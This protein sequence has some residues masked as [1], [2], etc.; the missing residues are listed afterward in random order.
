MEARNHLG[1]YIST[2]AATVVSLASQGS[3]ATLRQCFTVTAEETEQHG[4]QEL[5]WLIAEACA[6]RKI[7]FSDVAVALDCAAF[8]QHN[9]HSEF[10]DPK[11]IAATIRFDAEEAL[12]MD[13]TDLA[14]AFRVIAGDQTGS[15]LAVFTTQKKQL[16]DILLSLQSKKID[17]VT[18][19]PDINSLSRF[20]TQDA[21]LSQD[22]SSL[23]CALSQ[24]SAYFIAITQASLPLPLRT[25]LLS[26]SHDRFEL[27]ARQIPITTALTETDEPIGSVKVFD[28][29]GFADCP[30]LS[31]KL[32]LDAALFDLPAVVNAD[33]QTLADCADPVDFAVAYGAALS[34]FEK[35][36]TANFRNDFMPYQGRKRRL[37]KAARFISVTATALLIALGLYFQLQLFQR[38]KY[39]TRLQKKFHKEYSAVMLGEKFPTKL[40]PINKLKG[41]VRRIES[42]KS[43]LLSV[44]GEESITAKLTLVL[45]AFNKC[46]KQTGLNVESVSITAKTISIVGDTSSRQNTLKLFKAIRDTGLNIQQQRLEQKSGRDNFRITVA[47]KK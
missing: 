10:T 25:F 26:P 33:P 41:E 35:V 39:R 32:G 36:Q 9:I 40:N 6:E 7:Q 1:I 15:K 21:S 2:N 5:A 47:P 42:V 3:G 19:E 4:P 44:T 45:E 11:Q 31:E 16:S 18:I 28:S 43:G 8:M 23:L 46:A 27:L 29:T 20:I 14:V 24:R 17:P 13:I 37:Q 34:L 22:S 12:A 30:R 38:N